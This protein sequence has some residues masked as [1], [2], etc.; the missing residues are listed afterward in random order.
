MILRI[1]VNDVVE[2]LKKSPLRP[3]M[4]N[5]YRNYYKYIQVD[6]KK[7]VD[8][9]FD[10]YFEKRPKLYQQYHAS[11]EQHKIDYSF[12]AVKLAA[13]GGVISNNPDG[14]KPHLNQ[15]IIRKIVQKARDYEK[16]LGK[17]LTVA[18]HAHGLYGIYNAVMGGVDTIEHG[19][20]LMDD[21]ESVDTAE[22]AK[23]RKKMRQQI[24]QKTEKVVKANLLFL[25]LNK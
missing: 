23:K 17:P 2:S 15:A 13:T 8:T 9:W 11:K 19:T 1:I 3:N 25:I 20:A 16:K 6:N 4:K 24:E 18:A 5:E 12:D 10:Y 14:Y 7:D 21:I 22:E